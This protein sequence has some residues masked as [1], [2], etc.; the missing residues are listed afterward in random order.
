MAFCKN[1]DFALVTNTAEKSISLLNLK[2]AKR[3]AEF[4]CRA[5]QAGLSH[6]LHRF[7]KPAFEK[8]RT[9]DIKATYKNTPPNYLLGG[10]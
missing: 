5:N 1:R 2:H 4:T 9:L 8:A 7:S 6:S 3:C 10:A